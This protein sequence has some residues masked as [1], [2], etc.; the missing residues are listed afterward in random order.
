ME[1]REE[2]AGV[3]RAVKLHQFA[4]QEDRPENI[5]PQAS[6]SSNSHTNQPVSMRCEQVHS[7]YVLVS[8]SSRGIG[9]PDAP[10]A[11]FKI[12]SNCL[13]LKWPVNQGT[14]SSK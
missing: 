12:G 9:C 11:E 8:M 13:F 4:Y 5:D 7:L 14:F 10:Q 3:K 1:E 6:L 2:R